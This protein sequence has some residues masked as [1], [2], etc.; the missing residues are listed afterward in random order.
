M[1]LT[2]ENKKWLKDLTCSGVDDARV[3]IDCRERNGRLMTVEECEY[4]L[5]VI[6]P[7]SKTL[8]K[9]FESKAR[10]AFR[11]SLVCG[12]EEVNESRARHIARMDAE[13]AINPTTNYSTLRRALYL[14]TDAAICERIRREIKTRFPWGLTK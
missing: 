11:A 1:S 6:M 13:D 2:N 12:N 7:S 10:K 3:S 9:L 14:A 8:W 5:S 4:C